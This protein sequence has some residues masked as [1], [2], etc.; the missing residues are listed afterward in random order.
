MAVSQLAA[1][2]AAVD[3]LRTRVGVVLS[4][5]AI[6]T[7]FLA[8]QALNTSVGIPAP[9]WLGVS[10]GL[11]LIV[12]S[13][14]ILWPREW[15][16][17]VQDGSVI[18]RDVQTKPDRDMSEYYAALAGFAVQAISSNKPRLRALYSFFS[19]SL[20]LLVLDFAGWIWTLAVNNGGT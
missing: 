14:V 5:A 13:A 6:A 20:G 9:A 7:G 3:E 1:Q 8:G 11:S 19:L 2:F 16:G 18:L 17:Q 10:A 12:C 4:G 15:A